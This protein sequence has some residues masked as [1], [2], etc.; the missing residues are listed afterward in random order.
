MS[1]PGSIVEIELEGKKKKK[2]RFKRIFVALKPCI[3]GFLAGCRPFIGVDASALHGKYRGQLASATSVD[4]HNWLYHVAYGVFDSE[5]EDNWKWFMQQLHRAVGSPTGLGI[6]IDDCKG[7]EKVVGAVFPEVEYRECMRHMYSNFM[8]QYQG[9]VFTDHLYPA[10]RSYTEGLFRWHMQKIADF[11][12]DAI[13]F[14]QQHHNLIWYRCG[15]SELS[16]CDY[17]TNNVSES[18]NAQIKKLKGLLLHELVDGIR[19]LIMERGT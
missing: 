6:C 17:L 5:T 19:E 14:L 7:L 3:D 11:A 8:K 12:P 10:A 16:K 15:F 9:D 4:G 1:S 18:F 13:D 2:K